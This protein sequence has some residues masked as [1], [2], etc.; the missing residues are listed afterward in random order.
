MALPPPLHAEVDALRKI[1]AHVEVSRQDDDNGWRSND[2]LRR[3]LL[4][5][6]LDINAAAKMYDATMRFRAARHADRLLATYTAPLALRYYFGE[7]FT[8]VDREGYPV[9]VER[10][11]AMDIAGLQAAVGLDAFLEWVVFYH[12]QQERVMRRLSAAAGSN[13]FRLTVIVDMTGVSTKHI[14]SAALQASIG[15]ARLRSWRPTWS[16]T[17]LQSQASRASYA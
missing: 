8:G 6:K 4:A 1:V 12:E 5:R 15:Y 3:F 9:L 2:M 10:V 11:G 13:R 16:R 17:V 7:G 14:S